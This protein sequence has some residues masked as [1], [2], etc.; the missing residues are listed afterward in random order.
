MSSSINVQDSS[1]PDSQG[2]GTGAAPVTENVLSP[3]PESAAS[4]EQLLRLARYRRSVRAFNPDIPVPEGQVEK[5]LDVARWSPSA[6]NAQPWEFVVVRDGEMRERIANLYAS[7][8]AE[9]REMQE[10]VWGQR[11]NVGYTGFRQA[12]VYIIILGDS[13]VIDAYPVRTAIEK[14]EVHVIASLAQAT[15]MAHLAAASLGLGSQWVSDTSSPYMATM[16]KSWLNIPRNL[17][18][19]D[20]MAVGHPATSPPPTYRR[21][22]SEIVHHET[23]DPTRIRTDEDVLSFLWDYTLLGGFAKKYDAV[24]ES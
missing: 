1:H 18:V 4:Y 15:V 24:D 12:P 10:A 11:R 5:I 6:G 13:R 3:L 14:G 7:Q 16:I 22:T 9:K 23:Y 20:M 21:P 19:F 17:R 8:M 2:P